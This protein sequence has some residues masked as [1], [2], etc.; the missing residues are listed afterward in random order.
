MSTVSGSATARDRQA[1]LR[2]VFEANQRL[3]GLA[4]P[5]S[6][7]PRRGSGGLVRPQLRW[8]LA[9]PLVA[10]AVALA[11]WDRPEP[12]PPPVAVAPDPAPTTTA[13][14]PAPPASATPVAE[15]APAAVADPRSPFGPRAVNGTAGHWFLPPPAAG[16]ALPPVAQLATAPSGWLGRAQRSV[17]VADAVT[18]GAAADAADDLAVYTGTRL[19]QGLTLR[20][21]FGLGVRTIVVDPGHGGRDPGTSGKLGTY[22]KD[23]TLDVALRLKALLEHDH[24]FR[25]VLTRE[26]DS[27]VTLSRRVKRA[28]AAAVDLFVSIHVNSLPNTELNVVETYYFGAHS[29]DDALRLAER[30]NHGS[31]YGVSDFEDLVRNMRDTIKLQESKRLATSIQASLTSNMQRTNRALLDVGTKTAPFVVL[32]GV[33]A[34]AV[35]AEISCMCNPEAEQRLRTPGHREE[36]ARYIAEG[37]VNYLQRDTIKGGDANDRQRQ[38]KKS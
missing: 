10:A 19:A 15:A 17:P 13:A 1:L 28:N 4:G 16:L 37:I 33:K 26:D 7:P 3:N 5:E 9:V 8:L 22:E 29:D 34:P 21:I 38:A 32:L 27:S 11:A 23:V 35:L 12:P 20:E 31:D 24:S 30:E 2:E 36:I 25:V 6:S 14:A 18:D